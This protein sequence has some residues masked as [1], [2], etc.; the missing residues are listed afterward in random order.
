LLAREKDLEAQLAASMKAV[1]DDEARLVTLQAKC[2]KHV[3]AVEARA[4]KAEKKLA[5]M[6]QQQATREQSIVE[7]V[8]S[9]STMFGSMFFY[10]SFETFSFAYFLTLFDKSSPLCCS[11]A[12][13][14]DLQTLY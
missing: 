11:R 5:E 1:S 8:D 13:W 7:R 14:R 3:F 6:K 2:K 12:D 10:P 9:M 4:T